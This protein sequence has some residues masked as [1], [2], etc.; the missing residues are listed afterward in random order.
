MSVNLVQSKLEVDT[1]PPVGASYEMTILDYPFP[2]SVRVFDLPSLFA[3]KMHA[4]LCRGYVKGRDWYDFIWYTAHRVPINHRLLSAALKQ[5]GPWSGSDLETNDNWCVAELSKV[6][7][8]LDVKKVRED[9]RRFVRP[10]E[11]PSL[12]LWSREFFLSQ[13]RKLAS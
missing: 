5:Q 4:L 7:E 6:I 13:C 1:R 3:G 12:E 10:N 11:L 2:S 9:V 8:A